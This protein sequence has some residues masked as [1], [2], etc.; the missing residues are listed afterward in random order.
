[1]TKIKKISKRKGKPVV[2]DGVRYNSIKLAAQSLGLNSQTVYKRLASGVALE[3]A[4]VDRLPAKQ[5]GAPRKCKFLGMWFVSHQAR[6]NFFGLGN[7]RTDIVEKRL[8]RG[9]SERQ[10]VG[11]DPPPHR[12]KDKSGN[13]KPAVYRLFKEIDGKIYPHAKKGDFRLYSIMNISNKKEYVGITIQ[14]LNNRLKGHLSE[15]IST[16]STSKLHRAI[17]KYGSNKF[18]ISLL[19]NDAKNYKE[20]ANQEILEITK[21]KTVQFGYNTSLGGDL[22]TS[23]TIEID[24]KIF[25][26]WTIAAHFYRVE[27]KTFAQRI[28]KLKWSPEEAAGLIIR[29]KYQRKQITVGG[30][31]FPNLK[32]ASDFYK[33]NYK[34]VFQRKQSGWDVEEIFD[35]KS[36]PNEKQMTQK[37][38]V[39]A[40]I[41]D[42]QAAFAR[43]CKVSPSQITKLKK[44]LAYEEIY[45]KYLQT[46]VPSAQ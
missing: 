42:S 20:L 17:R 18:K 24:G 27:P 30:K 34:A 2:V 26:S 10:A 13:P 3:D 39:G 40:H 32:A 46:N 45:E 11:L 7:H 25:P 16:K 33:M 44:S 14:S 38:I 43:F 21:R 35:L 36:P 12:A 5:S 1:M 19:R 8:S 15:A 4:F 28:T 22:G 37:V 9:W 6:N 29:Q 31:T 41:F 23:K